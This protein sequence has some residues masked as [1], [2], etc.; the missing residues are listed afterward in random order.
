MSQNSKLFDDYDQMPNDIDDD[1]HK[2]KSYDEDSD[3]E[4]MLQ[5]DMGFIYN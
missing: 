5:G 3:D 4:Y 1:E 2:L